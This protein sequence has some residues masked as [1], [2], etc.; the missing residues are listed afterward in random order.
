VARVNLLQRVARIVH[1][2]KQISTDA[3]ELLNQCLELGGH[4]SLGSEAT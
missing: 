1:K 4:V 3:E 2:A